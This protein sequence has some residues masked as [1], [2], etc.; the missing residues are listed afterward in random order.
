MGEMERR[1]K[2][3]KEESEKK[4]NKISSQA[5][6]LAEKNKTILGKI[7]VESELKSR[8]EM[9]GQRGRESQKEIEVLN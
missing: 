6:E 8:L 4:E 5:S 9:E 7:K 2:G 1:I 3:L